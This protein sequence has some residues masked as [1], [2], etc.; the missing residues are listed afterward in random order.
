MTNESG[1]QSGGTVRRI[2]DID[3][4]GIADAL[5]DSGGETAWW[6]DPSTGQIEMRLPTWSEFAVDDDDEYD[7][8]RDRGLIEIEAEGSRAAYRDMVDF[9]EAVGDRVVS[10]RLLREL[11][12]RGAFRRFRDAVH[13]LPEVSERWVPYSKACAESR[14]I[15]WLVAAGQAG[16]IDAEHELVARADIVESVTNEIG[17]RADLEK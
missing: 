4:T 8:P 10:E 9:A 12:G 2:G 3:V 5:G 14:A 15:H 16:E 6:F 13:D 7:D 11:E 1:Q 17:G